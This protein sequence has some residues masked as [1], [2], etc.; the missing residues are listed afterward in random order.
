M[1]SGKKSYLVAGLMGLAVFTKTMG[2]IDE[3]TYQSI[4]G[5]LSALGLGALRAGI[6]KVN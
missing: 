2:W 4:L 5:L 6:S 3:N 1:L